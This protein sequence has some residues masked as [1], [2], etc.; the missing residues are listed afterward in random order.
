[1]FYQVCNFFSPILVA[2]GTGSPPLSTIPA[3]EVGPMSGVGL[4]GTTELGWLIPLN[5]GPSD[6]AGAD[7]GAS[8]IVREVTSPVLVVG[9]ERIPVSIPVGCRDVN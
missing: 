8:I 6:S 5:V 4:T 3:L 1:M 9:I 2:G 7:S